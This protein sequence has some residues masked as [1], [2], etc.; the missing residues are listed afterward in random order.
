[1]IVPVLIGACTFYMIKNLTTFGQKMNIALIFAVV[2]A[3][4]M[5]IGLTEE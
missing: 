2:V 4:I 5:Y 1:M 3:T